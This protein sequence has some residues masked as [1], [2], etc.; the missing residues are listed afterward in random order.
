MLVNFSKRCLPSVA[1][2]CTM[3]M[4]VGVAGAAHIPVTI[5]SSSGGE[6]GWEAEYTINGDGLAS[7]ESIQHNG[8]TT[9]SPPDSFLA[10]NDF[11]GAM[12]ST[13]FILDL[14]GAQDVGSFRFWNMNTET[15]R[16]GRGYTQV[17]VAF[18]TTDNASFGAAESFF[19]GI[20]PGADGYEGD[21]FTLTPALG[22]TYALV[23]F[24]DG[25]TLEFEGTFGGDS[26]AGFSE[27]QFYSVI[28]EPTTLSLLALSGLAMVGMRRK[29]VVA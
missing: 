5:D 2:V 15:S 18:S 8:S 24:G 9:P 27:M 7:P 19:P 17:N 26:F 3:F 14:G 25:D 16:I 11:D 6:F 21:L 1:L 10:W 28:P 20:A 12:D 4:L 23:T 13:F 22:A 29:R